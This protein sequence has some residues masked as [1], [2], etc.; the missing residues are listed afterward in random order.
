MAE[1]PEV[2]MG[3][4]GRGCCGGT[5]TM[6][7]RSVVGSRMDVGVGAARI[8][9]RLFSCLNKNEISVVKKLEKK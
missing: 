9:L 1:V 4:R 2:W 6:G 7:W 5:A 8:A 3:W